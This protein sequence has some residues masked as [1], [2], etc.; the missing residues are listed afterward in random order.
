MLAVAALI[1]AGAG[2]AEAGITWR[3]GVVLS[4]GAL[5]AVATIVVDWRRQ[6]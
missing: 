2:T 6:A 3:H 4:L 5:C 1:L